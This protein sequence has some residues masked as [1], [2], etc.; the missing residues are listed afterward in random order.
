MLSYSFQNT[1]GIPISLGLSDRHCKIRTYNHRNKWPITWNSPGSHNTKQLCESAANVPT[2]LQHDCIVGGIMH[3]HKLTSDEYLALFSVSLF[4]VISNCNDE[5]HYWKYS[6]ARYHINHMLFLLLLQISYVPS[7]TSVRI[8]LF[9]A[10]LG[11]N[12]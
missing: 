3:Q 4:L 12:W 9:E 11:P 8:L 10:A 1:I 7:H 2:F 5:S 6:A